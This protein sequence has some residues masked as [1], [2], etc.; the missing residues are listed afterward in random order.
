MMLG[1]L[2]SPTHSIFICP[3][4][5]L[6]LSLHHLSLTFSS[7]FACFLFFHSHFLMS[8][9]CRS[10]FYTIQVLAV[11]GEKALRAL[12]KGLTNGSDGQSLDFCPCAENSG[13]VTQSSAR[14][15]LFSLVWILLHIICC[16]C[17]SD[18]YFF[19]SQCSIT[20]GGKEDK[21]RI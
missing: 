6:P 19:I 2:S 21:E 5:P 9:L 12:S 10:V 3:T 1:Y 16:C 13:S 20:S 8:L 11:E 4:F 18:F 7:A 15:R 14:V 17:R